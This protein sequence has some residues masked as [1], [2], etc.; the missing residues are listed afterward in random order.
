MP[1]SFAPSKLRSFHAR[2]LLSGS[3]L[4][5]CA[6]SPAE[7]VL[8]WSQ[9]TQFPTFSGA[10]V[11]HGSTNIP[12]QT[13]FVY[14]RVL[15]DEGTPF[16]HMII[17]D[18]ATGFAQETYIQTAPSNISNAFGLIGPALSSSGGGTGGGSNN[19]ESSNAADPISAS[20]AIGGNATGNP[21]RVLMRQIVTDSELSQE[22]LKQGLA[23][24]PLINNTIETDRHS[25]VFIMD[26]SDLSYSDME[27]AATVTN[28]LQILDPDIPESSAS[29]DMSQDSQSSMV[30]AGRY[31]Y[32][33]GS[34]AGGGSGGTY[35][36]AD[37]GGANQNPDWSSFFDSRE[38]NPWA[39]PE[40]RPIAP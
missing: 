16:Y 30:T 38:P 12:N 8:N 28:T 21:E 22:F 4:L 35:E 18:P 2:T 13:P 36:Y 3:L 11:T 5:Y 24:K 7:F 9:D 17:G 10:F 15:S 25:A 31:I 19:L 33:P 1:S 39:Y 26:G 29:F 34:S 23:G 6:V 32:T 27:T 20:A 40:N 14:E 37:G